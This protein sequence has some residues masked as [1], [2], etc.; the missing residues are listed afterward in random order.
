MPLRK[1][2][3]TRFYG[4]DQIRVAQA[5]LET[6]EG[7]LHERLLA[8]ANA[9]W[10]A[11]RFYNDWPPALQFATEAIHRALLAKPSIAESVA[12]MSND[13]AQAAIDLLHQFVRQAEA[14][15]GQVE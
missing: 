15:A 2:E 1:A 11:M 4:L 3:M 12:A 6:S 9:Y 8:A 10:D 14:F 5:I 7:V 13:E